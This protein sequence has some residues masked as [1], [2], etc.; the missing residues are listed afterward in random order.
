MIGF[1][2]RCTIRK[3]PAAKALCIV[4]RQT[5]METDSLTVSAPEFMLVPF[6]RALSRNW[7][8]LFVRNV[9]KPHSILQTAVFMTEQNEIAIVR[10]EVNVIDPELFL[11]QHFFSLSRDCIHA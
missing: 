1:G 5:T 3:A 7:L 8:T 9:Q 6:V 2:I 11:V 4:A 10:V